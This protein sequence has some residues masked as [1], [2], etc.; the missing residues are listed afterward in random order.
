MNYLSE[1][2]SE[3]N[4]RRNVE[5]STHIAKILYSRLASVCEQFA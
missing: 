2:E 4:T 5:M 1:S 3:T